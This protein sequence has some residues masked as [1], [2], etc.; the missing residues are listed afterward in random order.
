MTDFRQL[1]AALATE[2]ANFILIR[3]AAAIV[4]GSTHVTQAL[5][6]VYDRSPD[7]L[8]RI[9]RALAPHRPYLRD[10]PPG[11]PFLLD[12]ATLERGMNFTLTTTLG[13]IVLLGEITGGGT[14][15]T[16]SSHCVELEVFGTRALCLDLPT[17]IAVKRAADRPK[18]LAAIA[19][20]ECVLDEDE[21]TR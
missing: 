21:G 6:V 20:L 12:A 14:Y 5:D 16:L 8:R 18:D 10:V 13:E 1:L 4:H 7:N 11:L 3:G 9:A 17:L 15:V 2:R 19:E